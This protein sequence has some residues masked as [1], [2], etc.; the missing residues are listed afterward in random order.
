VVD[1]Q[2]VRDLRDLRLPALDHDGEVDRVRVGPDVRLLVGEPR[3]EIV[4]GSGTTADA[5]R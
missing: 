5:M 1:L 3:G 2:G 4:A